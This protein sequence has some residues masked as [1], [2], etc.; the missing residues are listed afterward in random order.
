MLETLGTRIDTKLN[1]ADRMERLNG[2]FYQLT[3]A[4]AWGKI[5]TEPD[6]DEPA[7]AVLSIG[8]MPGSTPFGSTGR[9][10]KCEW[11]V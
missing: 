2:I 5:T 7:L 9:R 4:S 1:G 3:V 11:A 10:L 8:S 6:A